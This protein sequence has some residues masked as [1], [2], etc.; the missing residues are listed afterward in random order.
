MKREWCP[1]CQAMQNVN[2]TTTKSIEKDEQ[3]EDMKVTIESD[4]CSVCHIFIKSENIKDC[5]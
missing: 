5:T 2:T 4:Q 1:K 3:G